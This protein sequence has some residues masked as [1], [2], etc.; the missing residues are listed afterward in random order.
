MY[1][2]SINGLAKDGKW[3]IMYHNY[4][5]KNCPYHSPGCASRSR[6]MPVKNMK[7]KMQGLLTER[8]SL[9]STELGKCIRDTPKLNIDGT[10]TQK[11]IRRAKVMMRADTDV[12]YTENFNNNLAKRETPPNN[13]QPQ[14]TC[15]PTAP[16]STKQQHPTA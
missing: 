9:G 4:V 2:K 10:F 16:A 11:T 7:M 6:N 8:D 3:Q 12:C 13:D 5:Q 1:A 14:P 15:H